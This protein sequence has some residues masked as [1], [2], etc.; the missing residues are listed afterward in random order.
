VRGLTAQPMKFLADSYL[1][2]AFEHPDLQMN[3]DLYLI[4][5]PVLTEWR[6]IL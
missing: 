5:R 2:D 1:D 3:A 4:L 6:D